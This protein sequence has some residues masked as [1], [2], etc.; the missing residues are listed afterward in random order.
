M[1]DSR[2][3]DEYFDNGTVFTAQPPK[4]KAPPVLSG[5]MRFVKL[6]FPCFAALLLGVMVVMPNIRKSIDLQNNVTMPRK[7]EMEQLHME[8]TVFS[9]TD[10]K[11]RVNRVTAETVD[12]TE[13]GSQKYLLVSP[14]G[15]IP[16]DSGKI[17]ISS[18]EGYFDQN[19]NILDLKQKVHAVVNGKTTIDTESGA[20]DFKAE[21][22]YGSQDVKAVGDWGNLSGEAWTFSKPSN[23]LTL[24]GHSKVVNDRGT[25]TAEEQSKY[26]HAEN[27]I[28][29][30]GNVVLTS[31]QKTVYADK[32][33]AFLTSTEPRE[34][35][36]VEAYGHVRIKTAEQTA[37][38][39]VAFYD[40]EKRKIELFGAKNGYKNGNSNL[41]KVLKDKNELQA[42]RMVVYLEAG[43]EQKVR[44]I[45]ALGQVVVTTPKGSAKG[46]RGEYKPK[47][48]LVELWDN[49]EISQDG[50]FVRGGHATTDLKTSISRIMGHQSG[51][52]IS[53][54]FYKK[55][56]NSNGQKSK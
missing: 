45:E 6:G 2:K 7:N 9:S 56:K 20:Y 28:E 51:G 8:N 49:V 27:K 16:T 14:K 43:K 53:G 37:T 29:A 38:A 35:K 1:V 44:Y 36:R 39:A 19:T 54:T 47:D 31:E 13:T 50:N 30:E 26:F 5:W 23:E 4:E 15:E 11:N 46:D 41:V 55:G 18:V 25:L 22:G 34:I 33:I 32:I 42:L 12:E 40:A 17:V 52:R 10:G 3:I 48:S 24:I 21:Y